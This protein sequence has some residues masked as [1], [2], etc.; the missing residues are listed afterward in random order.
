MLQSAYFLPFWKPLHLPG[1]P[2][3]V[4]KSR[5]M[6]QRVVDGRGALYRGMTDCAAQ[7]V[8]HEGVFALWRGL[9]PVWLRMGP[10][11]FTFW[12]VNE[13]LRREFHLTSF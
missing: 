1:T 2:A 4:L 3:D 12:I 7:T 5:L 8:R 11:S 9:L 13:R 10:W 6:N